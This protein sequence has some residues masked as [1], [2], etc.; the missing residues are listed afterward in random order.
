MEASCSVVHSAL[1][2]KRQMQY[3]GSLC[4][5]DIHRRTITV[6]EHML[7]MCS[8]FCSANIIQPHLVSNSI[9]FPLFVTFY[10]TGSVQFVLF[11]KIPSCGVK[12]TPCLS[13]HVC[14]LPMLTSLLSYDWEY[15]SFSNTIIKQEVSQKMWFTTDVMPA[16][17]LREMSFTDRF[18]SAACHYGACEAS[19]FLAVT[20]SHS[21]HHKSEIYEQCLGY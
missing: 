11:I 15:L 12:S 3:Y 21:I 14:I 1:L 10:H 8:A 17:N 6:V 18:A 19:F 2:T 4:T 9:L 7:G 20:L 16:V 5:S 13:F